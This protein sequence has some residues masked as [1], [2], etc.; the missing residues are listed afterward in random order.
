MQPTTWYKAVA[1]VAAPA[2]LI[3][4]IAHRDGLMSIF[5]GGFLIAVGEWRYYT[6][7]EISFHRT[8]AGIA[9]V[10]D[11]PR[12]IHADGVLFQIVGVIAILYGIY[13]IYTTGSL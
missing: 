7:K 10:T 9:K 12:K 1:L 4:L 5:G 6:G 2:F 3:V 13:L 8:I 11:V